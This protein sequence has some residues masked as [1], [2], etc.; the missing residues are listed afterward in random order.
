M[1]LGLLANQLWIFT[2]P[3]CSQSLCEFYT[4]AQVTSSLNAE[5]SPQLLF[6]FSMLTQEIFLSMV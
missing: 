1:W 3:A 5:A 2:V 4:D 6:Y